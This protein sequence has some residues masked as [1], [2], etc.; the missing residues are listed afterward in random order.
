MEMNLDKLYQFQNNLLRGVDNVFKRS[1]YPDIPWSQRFVALKGFR[2]VG[3]TTMLLQYL[4]YDLGVNSESLYVSMD[5]PE[6]YNNSLLDFAENFSE[7]GGRVL[8]VDETHKLKNWSRE[9]K[10][11]YDSLPDLQLIFTSSSALD[12]HRSEADLSRRVLVFEIGGLSFR[13]YLSVNHNIDID[14]LTIQDIIHDHVDIA[15]TIVEQ[16]S[17]LE[18][19]DEY[20]KYGYYPLSI[21]VD[22]NSI[23]LRVMQALET[24]LDVDIATIYSYSADNTYKIK[25]LLKVLAES[26]PFSVNI[27]SLSR[28]LGIG[29]KTAYTYL[30]A[31]KK[32]NVLNFLN[33]EGK[34]I[35][36]LQKPDKV[37]LNNT[38]LSHLFLDNPEIGTIRETFILNQLHNAN[39]DCQLPKNGDFYL[40]EEDAF[41]EVGGEN[42]GFEQ[43]KDVSNGFVVADGIEVGYGRKIPLWL[44]GFLY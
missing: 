20:L 31:L 23:Q 24:V 15:R 29:R 4:K 18:F 30:H 1:Y 13:E 22:Q 8:L 25:Q 34:G 11:I 39:V 42:K 21:G 14:K 17:P 43:L 36:Q 28:Q 26:P 41:F 38:N 44:F 35:S 7:K 9:V 33:R 12:I 40:T 10:S 37:Y 2:G 6:F 3:K 32:A 19:I 16:A 5:H 27:S